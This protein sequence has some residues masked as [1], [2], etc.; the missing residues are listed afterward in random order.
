MTRK[1][2][3]PPN[4]KLVSS[5][6][7]YRG[8]AFSVVSDRVRE[9]GGIVV[10][11]D[12]VRH[13]GSV[14]IMAVEEDGK[15]QRVLLVRQYRYAAGRDLWELPAGRIDEDEAALPAAK[16]ELLEETGYTAQNWQKALH[17]YSS[18]GFVDETMTVFL[19]RGL[20]RGTAQP[21][22]DEFIRKRLF[23]L[24]TLLTMVRKQSIVD[25][26]TIA[27]ALWLNT[28]SGNKAK[29]KVR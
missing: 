25:A 20:K 21:E 12:V 13:S 24:S 14:V 3:A 28:F 4:V 1:V 9:P 19:A 29:R 2:P 6:S 26:K 18:P 27:G 17:F 5:R 11:R 22:E 7:V 8:P 23:P 10:Q 15:E 16:R